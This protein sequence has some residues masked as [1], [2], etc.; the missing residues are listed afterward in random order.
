MRLEYGR[1]LG[2]EGRHQVG[3]IDG[4][5]ASFDLAIL[6]F[7]SLTYVAPSS[8]PNSPGPIGNFPVP[9]NSTPA[10]PLLLPSGPVSPRVRS[11]PADFTSQHRTVQSAEP[12]TRTLDSAENDKEWIGA[13]WPLIFLIGREEPRSHNQISLSRPEAHSAWRPYEAAQ[14]QFTYLHLP[15][16]YHLD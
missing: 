5:S 11:P 2:V 3:S 10:A 9:P 14:S 8:Q 7:E 13:R 12:E 1:P 4:L 15:A 6:I 16:S